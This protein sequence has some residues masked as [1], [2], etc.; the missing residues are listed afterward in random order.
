[1]KGLV[2]YFELREM[3]EGNKPSSLTRT[4]RDLLRDGDRR[5]CGE[6]FESI[7][8]KWIT[9]SLTD[10]QVEAELVEDFRLSGGLP[11]RSFH[12]YVLPEKY[13]IFWTESAARFGT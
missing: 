10:A 12:T 6:P 1:M 5:Y 11:Q 8:D 13:D 7:Y 4:D 2:R 3:W 9:W